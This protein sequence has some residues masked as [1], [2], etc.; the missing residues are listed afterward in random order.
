MGKLYYLIGKSST[1]KDTIFSELVKK[2]SLGLKKIIQYTTRPK[3]DGENEGVEYRFIDE[4]TYEALEKAGK[5]IEVRSYNTVYGIWRYMMV[6]DGEVALRNGNY[7]AVGT[8]ESYRK[9]A[10]YF[11]GEDVVPIQIT[12][13][14]GERLYRAVMRERNSATP[15]Y[16]ELCRRFLADEADFSDEKLRE[17]GLLLEDG[18]LVNA[19]E[20]NELGSCVDAIAHFIKETEKNA[21]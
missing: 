12:V 5:V 15:K 17:A 13:E 3:R 9:V 2:R 11:G 10:E 14:I 20:N 19:F 18:S 7:L 1:G 16:T 8:I 6:D 21:K 4:E